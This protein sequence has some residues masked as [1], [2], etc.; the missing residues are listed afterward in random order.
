MLIFLVVFSSVSA[1]VFDKTGDTS[2]E[3]P[4]LACQK[5]IYKLKFQKQAD[6]G[7][8]RCR[9]TCDKVWSLWN[10][11]Q[12]PFAGFQGD[13]L[14]KCDS[15]FRAGFCSISECSAQKTMEK[16]VIDQVVNKSKLSGFVDS[17]VM[18]KM[19]KKVMK[20]KPVNFRKYAKK[21]KKQIKK[22]TKPKVF[23]KN[24]KKVAATLKLLASSAT[25][26]DLK[27]ALKQVNSAVDKAKTSQSVKNSIRNLADNFKSLIESKRTSKHKKKSAK[28]IVK[29]AKKVKNYIKGEIKNLHSYVRRLKKAAN[30][31]SDALDALRNRTTINGKGKRRITKLENILNNL[32]QVLLVLANTEKDIGN[33]LAVVKIAAAEFKN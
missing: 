1:N 25:P 32:K 4:C 15:C 19:L 6:C 31:V 9:T 26:K 22:T 14:G 12:T 11:P 16:T 24:F 13:N 5:A 10:R 2:C 27:L 18:S 3:N 17:S 23:K 28:K 8:S 20:N 30:Q 21:I 33:T 29:T 7:N